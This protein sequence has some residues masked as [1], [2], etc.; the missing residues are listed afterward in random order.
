MPEDIEDR[1]LSDRDVIVPPAGTSRRGNP[2]SL[3]A[4]LLGVLILV[5]DVYLLVRLSVLFFQKSFQSAI[6][7]ALLFSS[8]I[9]CISRWRRGSAFR[10]RW[11]WWRSA[12]PSAAW[13]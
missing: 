11:D 12:R 7:L 2:L 10:W 3:F 13:N 8:V 6:S 4:L 9:I 1:D 5:L